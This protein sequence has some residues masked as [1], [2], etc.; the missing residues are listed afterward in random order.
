LFLPHKPS[1]A[2]AALDAKLAQL[3]ADGVP[4]SLEELA[5]AFPDPP[6]EH[7]ATI[8]LRDALPSTRRENVSPL[9]PFVGGGSMPPRSE[10]IPDPLMEALTAHL[11]NSDEIL[12]SIPEHLTN[13]WFSAG[14][15]QGPKLQTP[16]GEIR[17]LE[18]TLALKAIYE[19]ELS[20]SVKSTEALQKGFAVSATPRSESLVNTMI[21]VACAGMMC[22]AAEQALNR[23]KFDHRQLAQIAE[24]LPI[25]TIG[26]FEEAFTTERA[27]MAGFLQRL[28]TA[29]N[30]LGADRFRLIFRQLMNFFSG[31]RKP[32]YHDED[33]LLVLNTYDEMTGLEG[34]ALLLR[35]A[36]IELLT[37]RFKTNAQSQAVTWFFP[38]LT[39]A[40]S[41]A[42]E[43]KARLVALKTAL[44]IER[45]RL[46]NTNSLPPTLDALVPK[47][48][49][50]APRDPFDEQPLRFKKL[51]RGYVVYSIGADGVD[52]GG[53]ER[54]NKKTDYDVTII[55]E[56]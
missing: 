35:L 8:V 55:V 31:S 54:G 17:K 42:F 13:V 20:N 5:K 40:M 28:R 53:V 39:K 47:Y 1:P 6:P 29:Q 27:L 51:A 9:V 23:I 3:R 46:A 19:G 33:F 38:N 50:S 2:A 52:N 43:T 21:S 18:Q 44:A 26:R 49:S 7:D 36:E 4:L 11:S 45:F 22:D 14:W 41:S 24:S 37:T 32:M 16:L 12:R 25:D 30:E 34:K 56:R 10:R 15:A 48:C